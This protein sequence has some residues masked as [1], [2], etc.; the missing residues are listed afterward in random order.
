MNDVVQKFLPPQSPENQAF[1]DACQR[2]ELL[3][4]RCNDCGKHQFYPRIFCASCTSRAIDWVKASGQATVVTWTVVR[5]AVSA[6][7]T[8]DVPYIIALV[9]LQEG[10]VMMSKLIGCEPETMRSGIAVEV[11]FENWTEQ[12]AM[13]VFA[14]VKNQPGRAE[15]E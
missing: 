8:E 12:V 14:A 9:K 15:D 5:R 3:I 1:W 13:P 6:A 7:Y 4:Q 11:G 2:H 10:P